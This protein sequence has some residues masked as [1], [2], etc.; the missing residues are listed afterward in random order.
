M[1]LQICNRD[2]KI[3]SENQGTTDLCSDCKNVLLAA[4]WPAGYDVT[5]LWIGY[6][7]YMDNGFGLFIESGAVIDYNT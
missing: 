4:K 3:Q 2:T 6:Y 5:A 1:P 7:Y